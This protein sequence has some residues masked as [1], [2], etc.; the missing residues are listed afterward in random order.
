MAVAMIQ[1]LAGRAPLQRFLAVSRAA[2]GDRSWL[3]E[4]VDEWPLPDSRGSTAKSW[5]AA[6]LVK[7]SVRQLPRAIFW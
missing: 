6:D 3:E 7:P 4:G 1:R 5:T 2:T